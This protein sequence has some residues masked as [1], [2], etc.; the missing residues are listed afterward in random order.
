M[1]FPVR[2]FYREKKKE[3]QLELLAGAKGLDKS[4]ITVVDVYRPMLALAGFTEYFLKE[5]ILILGKTE[6]AYLATL[7]SPRRNLAIKTVTGFMPP[8]MIIAEKLE[9]PREFYRQADKFKIPLFR[10]PISTTPFIHRL[11]S[12]LNYKLAPRCNI[13][14]TLVD[15][16]GIGVLIIGKAGIGKSEL[17]LDLVERGH[18]FIADDLIKAVRRNDVIM[19]MG[20]EKS[21]RLRHHIEIRGV[22]IVDIFRVFGAKSVRNQKRIEVV[23]ELAF[24]DETK[25]TYER[26]GI[27]DNYKDILGIGIPHIRIPLVPGKNVS[28]IVE[29]IAINQLLKLRGIQPAREYDEHL[30]HVM[31]RKKF[32]ADA[33]EDESLE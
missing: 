25:D 16:Y 11:T 13:Q 15:I 18:R 23:V 30:K 5:R 22:G 26:L 1:S 10:T 2:T 20:C 28:T 14:G 8:C 12:Y 17:A 24:W 19:G 21:D 31:K 29:V 32:V 9:I 27:I 6:T 33:H 7:T 3:F 4:F